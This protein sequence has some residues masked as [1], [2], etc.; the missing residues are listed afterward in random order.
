[1]ASE[2][3]SL[4][5]LR[6]IAWRSLDRTDRL[7]AWEYLAEKSQSDL[8]RGECWMLS[9]V[10]EMGSRSFPAM[11]E[12][13]DT[14]RD[15]VEETAAG[16]EA[17]G[18]VTIEGEDVS[19]TEAGLHQA[20]RLARGPARGAARP[21]RRVGRSRRPGRGRPG[22]RHRPSPRDR[23]PTRRRAHD[24]PLTAASGTLDPCTPP[25]TGSGSSA[26]G[27]SF[28]GPVFQASVELRAEDEASSRMQRRSS[29]GLPPPTTRSRTGGGCCRRCSWC[30]AHGAATT[31]RET[32]RCRPCPTEDL[33][34]IA[35]YINIARGWMLVGLRRLPDRAEGDLGAGR[36]RGVAGAGLLGAACC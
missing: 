7:R 18:L 19:P 34:L 20:A 6:L 17:K 2:R 30:S 26:P 11:T 33:E 15:L 23:G 22:R 8:T 29:T 24:S 13:S 1:M 16:L 12:A 9:R 3:S 21:A 36:A 35:R 10:S 5:E 27:C 4:E 28:A 14:P 32:R 25:S 31:Y